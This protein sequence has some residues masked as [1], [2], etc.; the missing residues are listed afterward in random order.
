MAARLGRLGLEL[1]DALVGRARGLLV[2]AGERGGLL[3]V[4]AHEL[5][6]VLAAQ[7]G[8]VLVEAGR[9]P[10]V[11]VAGHARL[12][13]LGFGRLARLAL[14]ADRG[15]GRRGGRARLVGRPAQ[16][17]GLARQAHLALAGRLG[18]VGRR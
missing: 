1:G 17:V 7:L 3:L 13:H 12:G 15:Q 8:Q 10:R 11:V 18:E 6:G 16:G 2:A 9:A 5:G 4:A 14:G